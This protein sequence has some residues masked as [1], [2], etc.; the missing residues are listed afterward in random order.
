MYGML[1]K[2]LLMALAETRRRD[3]EVLLLSGQYS[4]AYY[5]T[6]YAVECAL[7][8]IVASRFVQGAIP[9]KI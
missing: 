5:L 2:S 9:P 8:A 6:G 1:T 7:K 3:A 4:G